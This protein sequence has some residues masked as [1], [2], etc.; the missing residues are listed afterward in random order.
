MTATPD[1][2]LRAA[3]EATAYHVDSSPV[4]P[5]V[6]RCGAASRE[7]ETLFEHVR[8]QETTAGDRADGWAFITAVNPA[9]QI[10][11]DA[12]NRRRHARL[13]AAVA[14]MGLPNFPGRSVADAR[15]WPPEE[16]LLV[17]GIA[18]A[19]ATALAESFGQRAVVVGS[20]GSQARL[21]WTVQPGLSADSGPLTRPGCPRTEPHPTGHPP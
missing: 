4:G 13:R 2:V 3:F 19:A 8:R 9:A 16:S 18:A 21:V 11:R 14:R 10:W 15:D 6:I 17:L 7:L 12:E 5:F 1:P 20:R